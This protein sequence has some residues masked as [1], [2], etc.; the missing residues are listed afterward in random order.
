MA[1][2]PAVVPTQVQKQ[3]KVLRKMSSLAEASFSMSAAT[4]EAAAASVFG[5]SKTFAT[6]AKSNT[7]KGLL[8]LSCIIGARGEV[9][10][11]QLHMDIE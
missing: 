10:I 5:S 9:R 6:T 11:F 3:A 4:L 7:A 2:M 8:G 1:A